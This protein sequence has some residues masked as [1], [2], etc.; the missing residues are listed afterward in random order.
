MCYHNTSAPRHHSQTTRAGQHLL[1][2]SDL[3]QRWCQRHLEGRHTRSL[4]YERSN[5][6]ITF[7][8]YHLLNMMMM[9]EFWTSSLNLSDRKSFV[10][11]NQ[12]LRSVTQLVRAG[13]TGGG[14]TGRYGAGCRRWWWWGQLLVTST[15]SRRQQSPASA[16]NGSLRPTWANE[17]H[18]LLDP[19]TWWLHPAREDDAPHTQVL[20]CY[21]K[22]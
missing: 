10:E 5:L 21:G 20:V 3:A 6:K 2:N 8:N 22:P 15:T 9:G 19:V 14:N 17:T 12:V 7:S 1:L 16:S 11:A 4:R 13:V 18:A